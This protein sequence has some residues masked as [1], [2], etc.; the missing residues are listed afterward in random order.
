MGQTPF[1]GWTPLNPT[2]GTGPYQGVYNNNAYVG[3]NGY[4]EAVYGDGIQQTISTTA[5][6]ARYNLTLQAGELG[7]GN[8]DHTILIEVL[9]GSGNVIASRTEVVANAQQP[10]FTLEYIAAGPNTTIRITNQTSTGTASSDLVVWSVNNTL[11][12]ITY[13]DTFYGDAG[14]DLLDGANGN[15]GLFGGTDNDTLYG[16][17]GND[18]I[19]GDTS[20]DTVN[21][22]SD[23][24]Y[25]GDGNESVFGGAGNDQLFGDAGTDSLFG[26]NGNDLLNGGAGVDSLTGGAGNDV[27]IADGTADRISDFSLANNAD[28]NQQNNDFVDL[29]QFYN[30]VSLAAWNAANPGQTYATPLAWLRADQANG[31]LEQAGGLQIYNGGSAVAGSG[32]TFDN[33]NVHDTDGI[34]EGT[35]G[36]DHIDASYNQD[37][38]GDVVDGNDAILPGAGP[39]DDSIRGYNGNDSI[40]AGLGNDSAE[41]GHD[42]DT[43][44]GGSGDDTLS[45]DG[46]SYVIPG[47]P[48]TNSQ[49][50]SNGT[51]ASN[52]NGWTTSIDPGNIGQT[53]DLSHGGLGFGNY[54]HFNK[55]WAFTEVD[56]A[57]GSSL[58]IQFQYSE[59]DGAGQQIANS[60]TYTIF[61]LLTDPYD[62]NSAVPFTYL[63]NTVTQILLDGNSLAWQTYA[64]SVAN[65]TGVPLYL[66]FDANTTGS[67]N[68]VIDNVQVNAAAPA[69]PP[70]TV[71]PIGDDLIHGEAGND[72]INGDGGNDTVYGGT[73]NDILAQGAAADADRG[74]ALPSRPSAGR[75]SG[76]MC[77]PRKAQWQGGFPR[78]GFG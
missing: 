61:R 6:G 14:N 57:A 19:Y 48:A 34:V 16:G 33:T 45:G 56:P 37:P 35:Q 75:L 28:G 29:S 78:F 31:T 26:G 64:L 65:A 58:N 62:L 70:V 63:G 51:F 10:F 12:P 30:T 66:R 9:D 1:V 43:I 17:A 42:N 8:A 55:P 13:D 72:V 69:I 71:N 18:T 15:D 73:G 60:G 52:M 25:A 77:R 24:I 7:G 68:P 44:H 32:L 41:G 74:A 3:L 39:N 53:V 76:S 5:A 4:E 23:T 38:T 46:P 40:E 20:G 11:V 27:F 21:G 67:Y 50:V 49:L 59:W 47:T 2:G 54:P 22:G 36:S